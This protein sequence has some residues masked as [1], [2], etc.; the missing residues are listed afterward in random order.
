ME[1][2]IPRLYAMYE[3]FHS[4]TG[5]SSGLLSIHPWLLSGVWLGR[6]I[7]PVLPAASHAEM[8]TRMSPRALSSR[9]GRLGSRGS[10]RA[11][12]P[13]PLN[14]P[15]SRGRLGSAGSGNGTAAG[16]RLSH[17]VSALPIAAAKDGG[18]GG[19]EG[20]V[21]MEVQDGPAFVVDGAL[22]AVSPSQGGRVRGIESP[23]GEPTRAVGRSRIPGP[24]VPQSR[25]QHASEWP[26]LQVAEGEAEIEGEGTDEEAGVCPD[27]EGGG[28]DTLVYTGGML[29]PLDYK[30]VIT[31]IVQVRIWVEA[32]TWVNAR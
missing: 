15:S 29:A 21:S 30:A 23:R 24:P 8:E 25:G 12:T 9:Q 18:T 6:Y 31:A 32:Q 5:K 26:G 16:G 11:A 19:S 28:G 3:V 20:G 17:P 7:S 13:L 27:G 22:Q 14:L 4:T 1:A 10:S 2:G